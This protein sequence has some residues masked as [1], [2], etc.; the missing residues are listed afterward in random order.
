MSIIIDL[1]RELPEGYEEACFAEKA[2]Q[3]KRVIDNPNDL[4]MLS[5][6]HLHNGSSLA[7]IST[8]AELMKLGELS[9]VAFMKRFEACNSWFLWNI[10]HLVSACTIEYKKPEWLEK[11]R[12][13]AMDAS[14]VSEKGRS[15]RIFRL[16]FALELFKMCCEEQKV[17]T[18]ETGESLRNFSMRENDLVVADRIYSTLTGMKHC[19]ENG[20]NF[21]MRLRNKA[22]NLYDL[23]NQK[24]NLLDYLEKLKDEE[25]LDLQA[26]AKLDGKKNTPLRICAIKKTPDAIKN[27][28]RKLAR[29]KSKKQQNISEETMTFNN[30]IVLITALESDISAEQILEL[31]RFRWQVEIYFKR[32]KS[33]MDFG[34]LPKKRLGSSFAWLNGKIMIAILIEK[35]ISKASFPPENKYPTQSLA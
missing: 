4:M 11:F 35:L 28:N 21:V 14:D 15:G 29:K 3:R 30:Y 18:Q 2:I 1:I 24:I 6:L 22:F 9:D 19:L 16:H 7:E 26:F 33:I 32:L 23:Q 20:A 12:V 25:T 34:E 8:I 31:Y 27:S 5:M 17:T 10:E 13:L